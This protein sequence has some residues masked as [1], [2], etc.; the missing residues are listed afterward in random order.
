MSGGDHFE[1]LNIDRYM[2]AKASVCFVYLCG[3][4]FRRRK[5]VNYMF[6]IVDENPLCVWFYFVHK[7]IS[8]FSS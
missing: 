5:T 8:F 1:I 6:V 2:Y 3:L 7:V 4:C